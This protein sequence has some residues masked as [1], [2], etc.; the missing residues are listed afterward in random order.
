MAN[1]WLPSATTLPNRATPGAAALHRQQGKAVGDRCDEH[2]M[3]VDG[4]K[5]QRRQHHVELAHHRHLHAVLR[6]HGHGEAQAHAHGH[7]VP[8]TTTAPNTSC[9]TKP[10]TRPMATSRSRH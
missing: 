1:S 5:Q 9:M 2:E 6:V 4:E 7:A 3:A 8:A 10:M